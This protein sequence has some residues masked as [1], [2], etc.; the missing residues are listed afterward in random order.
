MPREG[1]LLGAHVFQRPDDRTEPGEQR[2]LG[3]TWAVALA[4]PKSMTFGTG[5]SSIQRDRTLFGL[6]SRWMIP[7]WWACWIAWQTGTKS[8]SRSR[9]LSGPGRSSQ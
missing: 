9:G 6:I 4:T 7:F 8:S 1:R 2:P 3:Q 5:L